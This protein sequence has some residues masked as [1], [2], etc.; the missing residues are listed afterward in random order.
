[1]GNRR[2]IN[3]ILARTLCVLV[4]F[5][6][7]F[8]L[9]IPTFAEGLEIGTTVSLIADS[10]LTLTSQTEDFTLGAGEDQELR[11][12][13]SGIAPFTYVWTVNT[14]GG[15]VFTPLEGALNAP[16]YS[17]EDAEVNPNKDSDG[18]D[19]PYQYKVTVSNEAGESV[20]AVIKVLVSDEYAY[21][22]IAL[23]NGDTEV[24]S[25][26][27]DETRLV[28]SP[29]SESTAAALT[30]EEALA[31][32]CLPL[33]ICDVKLVN[34]NNDVV[35]YFG[36]IEI[37]FYVGAQYNGLT[38]KA[39]HLRGNTIDTYSGVVAEGVL[40]ITVNSL[41][42]F[43]VEV[44][45]STVHTVTASAGTGG[46]ISPD[47][48]IN[49]ANG[50]DKTFTFLPDA[51][52]QIA[53]VLVD[54]SPVPITGNSYTVANITAD[55][56]I[57]V[58]FS[59]VTPSDTMHTLTIT[60]GANGTVSPSGSVQVRHGA[61]QTVYFYPDTGY[62][63][64]TVLV[65]GTAVNVIGNS[66]TVSV[67]TA[68]AA[69][70]VSFRTAA[71]ATQPPDVYKLITASADTGGSISP[72]GSVSVEYGGDMY[73]YFIPN[74]GYVLDKVYVDNVEAAVSG[75]S[76]HFV[77]VVAAHTIRATF[78]TAPS[79]VT[80]HTI[81]A[82]SGAGGSISPSGSVQVAEG[83]SQTFSF[84]PDANYQLGTL[85]VDGR[86]ASVSGN[87]YT[88]S[89]ITA[90]HTISVTFNRIPAPVY[91]PT[92]YPPHRPQYPALT[93]T[94][95]SAPGSYYTVTA[96]S[97]AHGRVSP[98]GDTRV[99]AGKNAWFYFIPDEGYEVDKVLVDGAQVQPINSAYC[100]YGVSA[101]HSVSV[102]FRE[103]PS[104]AAAG[105]HLVT[106]LVD[107][108][109]RVSPEGDVLVAVGSSQTFYFIADE[110]YEVDEVYVDGVRQTL[111]G[112]QL[113]LDSISADTELSVSF[114]PVGSE[115][116]GTD[117]RCL[118][119]RLF[120]ACGVCGLFGRC[121]APWCWLVPLLLTPALAYTVYVVLRRRRP[122]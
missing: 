120:G 10:S 28:V 85:T 108:K 82:S 50:A 87:A 79:P 42:P 102:T 95:T 77:N 76:Y 52:W 71:T 54:G 51:G 17:L 100:F 67:V 74:S 98:S 121:I 13:V 69:V 47:G 34:Q 113:T 60:S 39:Y 84:I 45:D 14:D 9:A 2:G 119:E 53:Q 44:P 4:C 3:S 107:G 64:D 97:G 116:G 118:W 83:G 111:V 90:G 57:S 109:G 56:T 6:A 62:E 61:A 27:H 86:A 20:S 22:T 1:M 21:R 89:N 81:T 101:A 104:E 31:D 112:N 58:S 75:N 72:S 110:G 92:Y 55:R 5:A 41:S 49:V 63:L 11:V 88:F 16:Y 115:P 29:V 30:L 117:C 91:D 32:G 23:R 40:S 33:L 106:A 7:L 114:R 80:Y 36:A 65:N 46:S 8:S 19:I 37:D 73:F 70:N 12:S 38:L 96:S 43:M 25:Y 99:A 24:S 18:R 15:S 66:Y 35:P 68:A 59:A 26:M 122:R 78:K 105:F 93:P 94:P 103:K 48:S